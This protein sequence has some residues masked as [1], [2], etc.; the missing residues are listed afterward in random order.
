MILDCVPCLVTC[1]RGPLSPWLDNGHDSRHAIDARHRR[2][3]SL[4]TGVVACCSDFILQH[5]CRQ[6]RIIHAICILYPS[7]LNFTAYRILVKH[8]FC[9]VFLYL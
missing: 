5:L 3:Y 6:A 4:L 8:Y 1:L 2:S 9:P 7:E